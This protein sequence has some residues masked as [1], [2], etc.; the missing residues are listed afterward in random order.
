MATDAV[1][2]GIG[3]SSSEPPK[4]IRGEDIMKFANQRG[5]KVFMVVV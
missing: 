1:N 5:I 4:S 2:T 3:L